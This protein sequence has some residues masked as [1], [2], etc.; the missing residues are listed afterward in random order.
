MD[1][2]LAY[3]QSKLFNRAYTRLGI[4]G[5]FNVQLIVIKKAGFDSVKKAPGT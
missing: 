1:R 3:R 4:D 2:R 5:E